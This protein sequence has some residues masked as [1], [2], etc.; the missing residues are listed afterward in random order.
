MIATTIDQST[1][2]YI[3]KTL[4][5]P[6]NGT[7]TPDPDD[8]AGMLVSTYRAG[9][10]EEASEDLAILDFVVDDENCE[11]GQASAIFVGVFHL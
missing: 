11:H 8:V 10:L 5:S 4:K 3:I 2:D 6:I 9:S 7:R 1:Q